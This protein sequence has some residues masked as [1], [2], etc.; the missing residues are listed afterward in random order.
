MTNY[1]KKAYAKLLFTTCMSLIFLETSCTHHT[2]EAQNEIAPTESEIHHIYSHLLKGSYTDYVD[3]IASCLD[4]PRFYR[5]QMVNLHRSQAQERANEM[6]RIDSITINKIQPHP[7]THHATI[8]ITH[9]YSQAPSEEILLQMIF[10]DNK[11]MI[12]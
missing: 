12:K 5:E 8:H 3:H 10:I 2:T 6:G 4:K 7:D 9:H 1:L 11:W